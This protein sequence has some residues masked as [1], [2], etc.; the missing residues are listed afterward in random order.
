MQLVVAECRKVCFHF[1]GNQIEFFQNLEHCIRSR[2]PRKF[3][4]ILLG[5]E[6]QP[7]FLCP[8]QVLQGAINGGET[9]RRFAIQC[10]CI[11][12]RKPSD[13]FHI[14]P[15][16]IG[17]VL[18]NKSSHRLNYM[19]GTENQIYSNLPKCPDFS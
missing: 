17:G 13:E 10:G 5:N 6:Q 8:K 2:C 9:R 7:K 3:R 18:F 19:G 14:G 16:V 12:L 4:K 15:S 1:S 11:H